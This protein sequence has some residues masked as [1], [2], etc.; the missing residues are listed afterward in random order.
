V[1]EFQEFPKIPRWSRRIIVTEKIDGTNGLVWVSG[2]GEVKA[3][4]RSRWIT[5][6]QDNHGFARWVEANK[7][8]LKQL[9][10][11]YHYGEWWG[12]G[13]NRGYGLKEKRW[14]LLNTSKWG[15][16]RPK[17]C[18]VVPVLYDGMMSQDRILIALDDLRRLG[19]KAAE[20][21]MKPEGVVIFH[22]GG[23]LYFK[24]TLE[25]DEVPKSLAGKEA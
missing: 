22:L 16:T 12:S 21:Y 11:G 10:P 7:E 4:S 3:G 14:S 24:K 15:E 18:H 2:D 1:S 5:P 19:S 9:G 6:E 13:I 25:N 20:G 23:N 17:C 8:D